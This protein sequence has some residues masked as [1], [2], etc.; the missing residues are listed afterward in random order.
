MKLDDVPAEPISW[1]GVLHHI[2]SR[3]TLITRLVGLAILSGIVGSLI[4]NPW[5]LL[6]AIPAGAV[7]SFW[8]LSS[9]HGTAQQRHSAAAVNDDEQGNNL[10]IQ[11]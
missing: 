1:T 6:I 4:P 11:T 8:M 5:Q 9:V 10:D 7:A 3:P 2:L